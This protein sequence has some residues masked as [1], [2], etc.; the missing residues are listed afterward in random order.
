[1][2]LYRYVQTSEMDHHI[3]PSSGIE[4]ARPQSTIV[5][6]RGRAAADSDAALGAGGRIIVETEATV[7]EATGERRPARQHVAEG[8][9]RF[10]FVRELG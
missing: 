8:Y 7:L 6:E 1:M 2:L 3:A 9:S 4:V 5:R 10:G